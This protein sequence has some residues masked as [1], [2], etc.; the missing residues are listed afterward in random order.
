MLDHNMTAFT[1]WK[2]NFWDKGTHLYLQ[3]WYEDDFNLKII[4]LNKKSYLGFPYLTKETPEN[5]VSINSALKEFP[6][7]SA[8]VE[9]DYPL[10][11]SKSL[12]FNIILETLSAQ[13]YKPAKLTGF[14]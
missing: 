8:A 13:L 6:A 3:S 2:S 10:Q 9:K 7:I 12:L 1:L 5:R 4:Y 14:E 11:A